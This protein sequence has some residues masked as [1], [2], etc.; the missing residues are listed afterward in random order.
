[1][2][3]SR[4]VRTMRSAISPRLAIRIFWNRLAPEDAAPLGLE[5]RHAEAV[6]ARHRLGE[7]VAGAQA[8][9]ELAH[10][11]HSAAV[12]QV[13]HDPARDVVAAA[14]ARRRGAAS[15]PGPRPPPPAPP[16]PPPAP[17]PP[18]PA[19]GGPVVRGVRVLVR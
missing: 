1:M 17:P 4:H 12:Q 5:L 8:E 10:H 9:Q 11:R 19:A 16:P 14:R 7:R 18:P 2:P 15:P 6:E 3:S 13:A